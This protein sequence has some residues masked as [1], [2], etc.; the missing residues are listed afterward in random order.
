MTSFHQAHCLYW[1]DKITHIAILYVISPGLIY[2]L[3]TPCA[4]KIQKSSN[5]KKKYVSQVK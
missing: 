5:I 1:K 4:T 3:S 2:R